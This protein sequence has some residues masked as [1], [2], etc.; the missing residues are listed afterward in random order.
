MNSLNLGASRAAKNFDSD[1]PRAEASV[2]MGQIALLTPEGV[3]R[4]VL[5]SCVGLVLYEPASRWAA[6]A[7][8]VLPNSEGRSGP[9]GKFVDTAVAEMLQSLRR[10]GID[11]AHLVAK[12]A[13]GSNMFDSQGPFQIG[14]QNVAAA[15]KHLGTHRIRVA[16][17]HTGGTRGRRTTFHC[18]TGEFLIEVLGDSPVRL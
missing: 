8:M 13:G 16:G 6:M 14:Q 9:P 18:R 1:A 17:E 5:G 12:F 3:G 4:A 11:S 7:H 10:H 15:A 2:G